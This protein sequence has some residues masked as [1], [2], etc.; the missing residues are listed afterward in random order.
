MNRLII[1]LV[2]VLVLSGCSTETE[3]IEKVTVDENYSV[4][5]INMFKYLQGEWH[6]RTIFMNTVFEGNFITFKENYSEVKDL[7]A[8][9]AHGEGSLRSKEGEWLLDFFY[10]ISK[11]GLKIELYEKKEEYKIKES[12]LYEY[13][14]IIINNETF[15]FNFTSSLGYHEETYYKVK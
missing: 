12:P 3:V 13:G 5:Q 4:E 15:K 11:N 2:G 1:L 14:I 6:Q 7:S 10:F 9:R 8:F